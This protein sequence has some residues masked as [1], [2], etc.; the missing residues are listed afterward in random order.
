MYLGIDIGTQSL[1]AVVVDDGLRPVGAGNVAYAPTH[2]QPGWAEQDPELWLNALRPAIAK[3]L[4]AARAA[5]ADIRAMAVCGQLDGCIATSADGAALAPAII[6]M[7]RRAAPLLEDIDAAVVRDLAGLV[8]DATHMAA[9]IRWCRRHLREASKAVVWHQPVSFVVEALTGRRMMDFGL[10]ST[11][12]LYK[13]GGGGWDEKLLS[14][15]DIDARSLPVLA[16]AADVAGMLTADG[17][18]L[19]GLPV[20]LPVA[21]GTG[22]DFSSLLGAGISKPGTATVTIGTAEIVCALS[23]MP[24]VDADMLVET[25]AFPGGLYHLG[26]PGWLSGGVVRWL[27]SL[28][29]LTTDAE[30]SALAASAPPGANGLTFLPALTGAMAPRWVAG[31]RGAFYGLT[32]SHGRGELARAV[33]EGTAFAMRDVIDRLRSL[34]VPVET[35]RLSGGGAASDVWAQIRADLMGLPVDRLIENDA[36]AMGAA[37]LAADAVGDMPDAASAS[38]LLDLPLG[39]VEPDPANQ[40]RYEDA[41]GRYRKLFDAL[42]PMYEG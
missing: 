17:A 9:K 36:S 33:L 29:K 12:M 21:V 19:T 7:D 22:D 38:E 23:T 2:P 16:N 13:L 35:I 37:L 18:A 14:A 40:A 5:P 1:K 10:A 3:A 6:W 28:L 39:R 34:G 31:A 30:V 15:F 11:T 26:N 24:T 41:Y 8:L 32:P 25:H 4:A 42:A 20:G 27:V